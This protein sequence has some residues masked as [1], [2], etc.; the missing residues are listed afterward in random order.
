MV[1]SVSNLNL[2][3]NA[4]ILQNADFLHIQVSGSHA[5]SSVWEGA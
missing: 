5:P 3:I 1:G 2:K 4:T